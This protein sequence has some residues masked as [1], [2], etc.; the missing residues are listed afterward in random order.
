MS[1]WN[2]NGESA[3]TLK[4]WSGKNGIRNAQLHAN[5]TAATEEDGEAF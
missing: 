2:Y 5:N 3:V 4:K 1:T